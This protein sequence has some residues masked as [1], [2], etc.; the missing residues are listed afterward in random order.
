MTN[1]V[2]NLG[3]AAGTWA[4]SLQREI[5]NLHRLIETRYSE[6]SARIDRVVSA[7]EYNADKRA[8]DQ[9]YTTMLDR[10]SGLDKD[11]EIFKREV[12][13]R[14][15]SLRVEYDADID[16][17]AML[18]NSE[19]STREAER[20]EDMKKITSAYEKAED[21]RQSKKQWIYAAILVPILI[22]L[23]PLFLTYLG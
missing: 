2:D 1:P 13:D 20:L 12:T 4:W 5:D 10:F 15:E 19:K 18:L 23:I 7:T 16:K 17:V 11:V 21:A 8:T 22:A 14:L 6:L 9:L 3:P